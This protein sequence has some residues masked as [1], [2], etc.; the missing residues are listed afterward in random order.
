MSVLDIASPN[1]RRSYHLRGLSR[2]VMQLPSK[3]R[4]RY[5]ILKR[6]FLRSANQTAL[7]HPT[8]E[9]MAI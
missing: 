1:L 4:G 7:E 9:S 8:T 2:R 3:A 6:Y 5:I